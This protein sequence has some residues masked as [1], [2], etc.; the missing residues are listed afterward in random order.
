MGE[1]GTPY[2]CVPLQAQGTVLGIVHLEFP[3]IFDDA[4]RMDRRRQLAVSVA[5]SISLALANLRLRESLH[6][7]SIRDPLTGLYNRRFMEE[8][9]SRELSRSL[10]SRKSLAVAMLD[11]DHFKNFNDTYGHQAGDLVLKEVAQLLLGFRQG[12]DVAC[13][14]G[15]EEFVLVL[16]EMERDDALARMQHLCQRVAALVMDYQGQ[17]L[18]T[19]TVSIGLALFPGAGDSVEKLIHAADSALYRAKANGRNRVE[20]FNPTEG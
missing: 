14:F 11:L 10:R 5:D 17:A 18:P 2:L 19:I 3:A 15:G 9:L 20:W 8:A 13:R 1:L 12:S 7:L 16:P 4:E 6:A